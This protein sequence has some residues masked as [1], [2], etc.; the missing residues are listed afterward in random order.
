MRKLTE[1]NISD[2]ESQLLSKIDR[3]SERKKDM[4]D[5][6]KVCRYL[7]LVRQYYLLQE[8]IEAEGIVVLTQNANQRFA[9]EN[10][11]FA[12]QIK[13]SSQLIALEKSF[14]FRVDQSPLELER[15]GEDLL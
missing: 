7:N 10:P 2:L 1:K 6:E 14:A 13:I 3:F 15:K 4:V 5:Y 12:A 9:K 8:Q 11:A